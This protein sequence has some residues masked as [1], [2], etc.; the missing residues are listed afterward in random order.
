MQLLTEYTLALYQLSFAHAGRPGVPALAWYISR[1][2]TS[3]A[4]EG[5]STAVSSMAGILNAKQKR[6]GC[7]RCA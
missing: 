5:T 7:S 4:I 2:G 6:N 1:L 3:F